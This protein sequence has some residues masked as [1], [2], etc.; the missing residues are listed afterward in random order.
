M[1]TLREEGTHRCACY[2]CKDHLCA[3]YA[4]HLRRAKA[5]ER[6]SCQKMFF[7]RRKRYHDG[8][9][10]CDVGFFHLLDET[11]AHRLVSNCDAGKQ[12]LLSI[13]DVA[14]RESSGRALI[15]RLFEAGRCAVHRLPVHFWLT[16]EWTNIRVSRRRRNASFYLVAKSSIS[17]SLCDREKRAVERWTRETDRKS[18]TDTPQG[19]PARK[20]T[21][22]SDAQRCALG[23]TVPAGP[24]AGPAG[25]GASAWSGTAPRLRSRIRARGA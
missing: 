4:V 24:E 8:K 13:L 1:T 25:R 12:C 10:H 2:R 5:A 23:H 22:I 14:V 7:H 3:E 17:R 6:N 16:T 15:Q 21:R 18:W 9:N 11:P 19:R 20:S